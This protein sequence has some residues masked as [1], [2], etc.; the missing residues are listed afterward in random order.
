MNVGGHVLEIRQ[1]V[2]IIK[3]QVHRHLFGCAGIQVQQ[4]NVP[5]VF[6]GQHVTGARR[7]H[8]VKRVMGGDRGECFGVEIILPDVQF[9]VLVTVRRE[10]DRITM[11]VGNLV[12]AREG[13]DPFGRVVFQVI[14]PH[15]RRATALVPLPGAEFTGNRGIAHLF[16]VRGQ[17][18]ETGF[19]DGQRGFQSAFQTHQEE[20]AHPLSPRGTVG[21]DQYLLAVRGPVHHDMVESATGRH[22]THVVEPGQLA[23]YATGCRHYID[24]P[25]TGVFRAERD[26]VAVRG[27]PGEKFGTFMGSQ[28]PGIPTFC[29]Y[30]PDITGI[31]KYNLVPVHIREPEQTRI[32]HG[33]Q[34]NC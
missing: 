4:I 10:I 18:A 22:H 27:Q 17:A 15:I 6:I 31:H 1:D 3:L 9:L 23:G 32:I 28:P 2:R 21:T 12:G 7:P 20:P 25:R 8:H 34:R 13:G 26:P 19:R 16:A 14:G 29:R 5:A 30:G 33:P 24:L 11:P